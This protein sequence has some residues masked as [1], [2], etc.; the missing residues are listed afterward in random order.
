MKHGAIAM[1]FILILFTTSAYCQRTESPGQK[2]E[3]LV[4]EVNEILKQTKGVGLSIAII[5]NYQVVWSKG[6]GIKEVHTQDSVTTE[7]LFQSASITKSITAAVVMKKVEQGK[8]SLVADINQQLVSWKVPATSY[9]QKSVV[10]VRQLLS[11]TSGIAS[12]PF[13]PYSINDRLPSLVEVAQGQAPARNQPVTVAYYP[14]KK[15]SYTGAGYVILE[16]LLSDIEKKNYASVVAEDIFEPLHMRNSTFDLRL[17]N[18]KYTSVAS[19]HLDGNVVLDDKY[20]LVYPLSFGSLWSTPTDLARFLSEIQ[21]AL[22][23]TSATV[24]AKSTAREMVKPLSTTAGQ[25]A[26]GFSLEKRG[27]VQFFGHDGHNYGYICSM[28]GSMEGGYGMVIMTN[29]ENGWKAINKIKKLVGRKYW[30]LGPYR[31]KQ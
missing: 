27:P 12:I 1:Q 20:T 6:F 28:L 30:G 3:S 10:N 7:T 8:I 13:P 17:P 19:G 24:V 15:Y 25:Y 31:P 29:S 11:H 22:N 23:G 4:P 26:L 16:I 9:T 21:S 18:E 14:G 2:Y 5:E